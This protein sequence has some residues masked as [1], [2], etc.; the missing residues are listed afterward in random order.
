MTLSITSHPVVTVDVDYAEKV[1]GLLKQCEH[2]WTNELITD[3]NFP[4]KAACSFCGNNIQEDVKKSTL[5]LFRYNREMTA[6][7]INKDLK[8]QGMRHAN[9]W[10][11]FSFWAKYPEIIQDSLPCA[12]LGSECFKRYGYRVVPVIIPDF[13]PN[14]RRC[15]I[16]I[17][18]VD[19][20]WPPYFWFLAVDMK[21]EWPLGGGALERV[22]F[23]YNNEE[24]V[25][26]DELIKR[27][28]LLKAD[29]SYECANWL[30]NNQHKIPESWQDS[31]LI[32]PG[33]IR[34]DFSGIS[35]VPFLCWS[36][37]EWHLDHTPIDAG[38]G[39]PDSLVRYLPQ[40]QE[41]IRCE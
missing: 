8:D 30:L 32:F 13:P 26:G 38:F 37:R 21:Y 4:V 7:E 2:G 24:S 35:A 20:S 15:N 34:G 28:K 12:A 23:L 14:S 31:C 39:S 10:E 9:I 16:T 11:L 3:E 29:L 1:S 41:V 33:S 27:A 36:N 22:N 17:Y 19:E 40:P 18:P 25:H 5:H 6:E